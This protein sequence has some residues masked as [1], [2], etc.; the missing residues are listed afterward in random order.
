MLAAWSQAWLGLLIFSKFEHFPSWNVVK[1]IVRSYSPPAGGEIF[2]YL[3]KKEFRAAA[4]RQKFETLNIFLE[5]GRIQPRQGSAVG[6]NWDIRRYLEP[7]AEWPATARRQIYTPKSSS[8][9]QIPEK[10]VEINAIHTH[11]W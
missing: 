2:G 6:K 8:F 3:E 5:F 1:T 9:V 10:L 7:L 4:R 11:P